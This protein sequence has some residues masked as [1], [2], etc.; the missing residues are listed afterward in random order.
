LSIIALSNARELHREIAQLQAVITSLIATLEAMLERLRAQR[1]AIALVNPD[2]RAV[3]IDPESGDIASDPETWPDSTDWF[4]WELDDE[5]EVLDLMFLHESEQEAAWD[6]EFNGVGVGPESSV[7]DTLDDIQWSESNPEPS[8]YD[9]VSDDADWDGYADATSSP[10][11]EDW[12][13]YHA[14]SEQ[15]DRMTDYDVARSVAVG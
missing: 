7:A 13:E 10:S 3:A 11:P 15:L 1:T 6:F 12:A 2:G 8:P 14:W 4:F 9:T 5:A